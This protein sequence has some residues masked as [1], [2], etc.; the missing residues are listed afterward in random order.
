M[1]FGIGLIFSNDMGIESIMIGHA[2]S[3]LLVIWSSVEI[4]QQCYT[5]AEVLSLGGWCLLSLIRGLL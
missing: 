5:R 1:N 4:Q 2:N 3:D